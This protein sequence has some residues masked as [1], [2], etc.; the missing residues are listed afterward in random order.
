M[1]KFQTY[2]FMDL[3]NL[4]QKDSR[5]KIS[6]LLCVAVFSACS[7]FAYA[8]QQQVH[9]IGSNLPLKSV[10]NQLEKQTK[11]SIDYKL[12]DI[13]DSR[14]VKQ[15]PKASTVQK[16]V[17]QLLKG[18]DCTAIFSNGHIIIKKKNTQ[19]N[20]KPTQNIKGTILDAT[21]MPIIGANIMIKGT[22]HG[23]VT[24]LNG[25]FSLDVPA[26]TVLQI[27]YIGMANQEVKVDGQTNLAITMK[28]DS[29]ML[30]ELV[31]V[32][33]GSTTKRDLIASVSTVKTEQISNTPV[34]NLTQG[35]AGRSPGLIVQA[36]GGGINSKPNVSIRGGGDPIYVINGIIRS[37]DDF[38]NLSPDDIESMSILKD[39]S[40]TAVYGS[41]ATNG[42]IQVVTKQGKVGKTSI[43][44]D[45]SYSIA[46]PSI[47]D[48]K[49]SAYDRAVW[50]NKAK[51]NDGLADTF[52]DTA[53]EAFKTGSD[54]LNYA[55]TDWRKLV[56]NNWA[57]QQKHAIRVFGGSETNRYYVSLGH[58]GQNSLY[59]ND[60]H[61]M[62]RTT[63][64][65]AQS[66]NIKP[67]GLQINAAI[68]GYREHTT[69]PYTS[70]AEGY[71]QVFSHI[72]DK[73]P[74]IPGYNKYG[75]PYLLNDNP[76]A[77]TAKDAGY[78]RTISNVINGKGEVVWTVPWVKGLKMR[79]SSNYR[80]Y[81]N[82]TKKFRK[83]AAKY[84]WD[85]QEPNYDSKPLLRSEN[86]NGYAFTNQAFL[87]YANQFG[88][89]SISALAVLSSIMKRMKVISWV[90][91][92]SSSMSIRLLWVTPIRRLMAV[93]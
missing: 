54:P 24:D 22:T 3:S 80:Y 79:A 74:S 62:K 61:W 63:F 60:N 36:S 81:S 37:V 23:T 26:G 19:E 52:D 12:Q 78:K 4:T 17:E 71:S 68:D 32:G 56:L 11:L 1:L 27:S 48:K 86:S 85:S 21:G 84:S 43:E 29:E 15:M 88:K 87:E 40:A 83:D 35:L 9:L 18:T 77:E 14:I 55:N 39:A 49:L 34:A 20:N 64:R 47:W 66:T 53:L 2:K 67:L 90:V 93:F 6:R 58:I 92:T 75:L 59:K 46:Q 25:Q 44:Y 7:V 45:F 30:D 51:Q 89:H 16:V 73:L 65:L 91:R 10:F 13:D 8:Q 28:E 5:K 69:H 42:I 76:V 31:V 72:N 82:S 33:Y 41:R 50:A 38:A 57:P 70:S